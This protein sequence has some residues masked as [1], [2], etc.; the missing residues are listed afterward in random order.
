M[1]IYIYIFYIK[2]KYILYTYHIK[3]RNIIILLLLFVIIIIIYIYTILYINIFTIFY[4]HTYISYLYKLLIQAKYII[5]SSQ[6]IFCAQ[7]RPAHMD[8]SPEAVVRRHPM[9][10]PHVFGD[11]PM[12]F[13]N[14]KVMGLIW[15]NH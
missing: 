2:S 13:F 8:W 10:N 15:I 5:W 1:Y 11:H 6:H 7:E 14:I 9:G 12:F 3:D 4:I